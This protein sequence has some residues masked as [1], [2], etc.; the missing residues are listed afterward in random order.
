MQWE[1]KIIEESEL[2]SDDTYKTPT[3]NELGKNGW[4][5]AAKISYERLV[6]KRLLKNDRFIT[7]EEMTEDYRI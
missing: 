3:L 1:Y 6:F 2:H 4:E 7:S 5:L